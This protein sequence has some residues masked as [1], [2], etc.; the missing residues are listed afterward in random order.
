MRGQSAEAYCEAE[1]L[2]KRRRYGDW[3]TPQKRRSS[4]RLRNPADGPEVRLRF[5]SPETPLYRSKR[6][7]CRSQRIAEEVPFAIEVFQY[8]LAHTLTEQPCE[9]ASGKKNF[10]IQNR[11]GDGL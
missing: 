9:I 3:N 5:Q 1:M 7:S 10:K 11:G 4:R 6:R 8:N 2:Q